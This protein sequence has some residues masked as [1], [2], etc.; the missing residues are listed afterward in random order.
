MLLAFVPI[1]RIAPIKTIR[2][3][4]IMIAYSAA[5]WPSSD[6]RIFKWIFPNFLLQ[7]L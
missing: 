2:I 5:P 1:K 7:T 3:T 6:S 4:A